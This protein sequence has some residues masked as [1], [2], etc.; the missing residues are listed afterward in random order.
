MPFQK[1]HVER[2]PVPPTMSEDEQER[3]RLTMHLMKRFRQTRFQ[4]HPS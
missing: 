4:E 3:Q 2:A 1:E